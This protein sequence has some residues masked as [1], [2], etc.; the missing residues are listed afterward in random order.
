MFTT[1]SRNES[2]AYLLL[3]LNIKSLAKIILRP[4]NLKI[5]RNIVLFSKS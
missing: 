2:H 4:E 1:G 5:Q 3:T